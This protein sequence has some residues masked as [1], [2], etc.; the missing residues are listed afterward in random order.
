[1]AVHVGEAEPPPLVQIRKTFMIDAEEMQ[2]SC[3]QVVNVDRSRSE[4]AFVGIDG[5]AI[6]VGNVIS[7]IICA[8]IGHA[9]F[10][11]AAGHPDSETARMV[12]AAIIVFCEFALR[13][14]S[15]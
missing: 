8:A 14:T 7:V 10:D 1:M 5:V 4:G 11:A 6:G 12:I 2:D 15:A 13:I 9:G 3:L